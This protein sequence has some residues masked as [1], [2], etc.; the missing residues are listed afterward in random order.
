MKK[1]C[2]FSF[3]ALIFSFRSVAQTSVE[4]IPTGGYT[5]PDQTNFYNTYG[6]I[7]GAFNWG[8]SLM[9]NVNRSFGI[10]FM[11]NR[12]NASSGIYNYSSQLPVQTQNVAINYM[13]A[14]PVQ[15]INFP[16]SP[17]QLFIGGLLGAAVFSPN[18]ADYTSNA[19]FAWGLEM[20]TNIYVDPRVGIRLKAQLLSPVDGVNG[21]YYFGSYGAGVGVSGYSYIYQF[22]FSAGLIIGLGR[23]FPPPRPRTYNRRPPPPPGY[24]YRSPY[25]PPPPPPYYYH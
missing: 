15:N 25:P 2:L 13:M 16:Q 20:G 9:L 17:V 10:E 19:K 1:I 3:V 22:S 11:Y 24:Y 6:R 18:P 8:G 4:L 7:E 12:I 23:I 14:G 5:F 21:G